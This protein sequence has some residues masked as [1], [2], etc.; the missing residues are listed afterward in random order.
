MFAPYSGSQGVSPAQGC[1]LFDPQRRNLK[2]VSGHSVLQVQEMSRFP[3]R[4]D[5]DLLSGTA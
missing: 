3:H 5:T 2:D 1:I 4:K